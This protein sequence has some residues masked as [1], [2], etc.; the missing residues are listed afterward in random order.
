MIR[1][2]VVFI[3]IIRLSSKSIREKYLMKL[4]YKKGQ[5]KSSSIE[6]KKNDIVVAVENRQTNVVCFDYSSV[7][8]TNRR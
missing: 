3:L 7:F 2:F 1:N 6:R 4:F 5:R 8:C